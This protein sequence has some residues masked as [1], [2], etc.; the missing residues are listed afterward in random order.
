M[1]TYD[2]NV[3]TRTYVRAC[4]SDGRCARR[5]EPG[6][7]E[8]SSLAAGAEPRADP[9]AFDGQNLNRRNFARIAPREVRSKKREGVCNNDRL[10]RGPV[11]HSVPNPTSKI[12]VRVFVCK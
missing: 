10:R 4:E 9:C 5:R 2:C 3:Y 8:A 6:L 1:C 11:H 7:L 12:L